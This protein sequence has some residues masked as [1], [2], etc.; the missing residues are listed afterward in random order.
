MMVFLLL[1]ILLTIFVIIPILLTF[2]FTSKLSWEN[3]RKVYFILFSNDEEE[4]QR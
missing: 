2:L 3:L 1:A 4:K